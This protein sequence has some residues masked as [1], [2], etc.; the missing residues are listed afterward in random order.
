VH[1]PYCLKAKTKVL[2]SRR[3]PENEIRRRR[4]CGLC[5]KRW[6]TYEHV[7]RT[8]VFVVK[9][10]N[11]REPFSREKVRRGIELA[12][13]KRGI[14][15]ERIEKSV[16]RIESKVLAMN[17]SEMKSKIIGQLVMDELM[18]LDEVAYVR[19][20]SVHKKFNDPR[21]F[22]NTI[23]QLRGNRHGSKDTIKI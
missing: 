22:L 13:E 21:Q 19:F 18:L 14:S 7:I 16:D 4:E 15:K 12:V 1:C 17:K 3:T 20:A 11:E 9:R 5:K 6:T 8:D 23:T 2:E 10:G